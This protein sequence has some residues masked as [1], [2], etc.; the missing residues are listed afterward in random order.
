MV[1]IG[2]EITCGMLWN[3][4]RVCERFDTPTQ[5]DRLA[6]LV[7]S[8]I[9]GVNDGIGPK[10]SIKIIIHIDRGADSTGSRWFFDNLRAQGVD[11][12]VIGLSY[13]PW[14]HGTL[15]EVSSNLNALVQR[16]D[17]DVMIVETAYPWTLAWFDDTHNIVGLS[18]HLLP[19]YPASVDGQRRFLIDLMGIVRTAPNGRG[20]GVFYWSPEYISAPTLGSPV[21]NVTLF[22]FAGNLLNSIAAFDSN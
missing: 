19:G 10:D 15:D 11:F 2:N 5:W 1:Q 4:G 3:D 20:M 9:R 22:D 17:K 6:E 12:D 7:E 16:Y 8:A 14:W 21:E 13:Y 18:E